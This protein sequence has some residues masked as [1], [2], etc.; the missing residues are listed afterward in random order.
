MDIKAAKAETQMA[1]A[2]VSKKAVKRELI[3]DWE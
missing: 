2:S 3:S 1:P